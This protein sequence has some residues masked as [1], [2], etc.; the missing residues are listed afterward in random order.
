[1]EQLNPKLFV[2]IPVITMTILG[3]MQGIL[4]FVDDEEAE[5]F[6][7]FVLSLRKGDNHPEVKTAI[8]EYLLKNV[9]WEFNLEE[10]KGDEWTEAEDDEGKYTNCS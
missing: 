6:V 10:E 8:P 7:E 5:K 1:M 2:R 4:I 9:N 3:P